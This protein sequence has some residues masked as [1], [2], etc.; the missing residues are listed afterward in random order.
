M[1]SAF[2]SPNVWTAWKTKVIEKHAYTSGFSDINGNCLLLR[3]LSGS[4]FWKRTGHSIS[5]E[6]IEYTLTSPS[7]GKSLSGLVGSRT[8]AAAQFCPSRTKDA[9]IFPP[10][11]LHF[12]SLLLCLHLLSYLRERVV[13]T[14]E[15][16]KFVTSSFI[17]KFM[18]TT[19]TSY[20][21]HLTNNPNACGGSVCVWVWGCKECW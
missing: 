19:F 17:F 3:L 20:S 5:S 6:S 14:P 13:D 11:S 15:H 16:P 7:R 4:V 18:M 10:P 12:S 1:P 8:N 2:L 21:A 9:P